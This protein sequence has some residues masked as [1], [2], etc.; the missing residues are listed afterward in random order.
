MIDL[1]GHSPLRGHHSALPH[2]PLLHSPLPTPT[3]SPATTPTRT[4]TPRPQPMRL[5][6]PILVLALTTIACR[7]KGASAVADS[8]GSASAVA[9][10][11]E[12]V[13]VKAPDASFSVMLPSHWVGVFRVDTLST[14]ERGSA[15][16]GALNV[17]Y[18]PRDSSVIPQTLVVVAV[19]DSAAW[20]RVKAAGGP[21]PGDSVFAKDGRVYILGLPQS[22]PFAP[23]SAD[24]LK[25]DSLAL[26]AAD[27]ARM[28]RVP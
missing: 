21:P 23:G 17:V 24:A 28:I 6:G 18:L 14:A 20:T 13:M 26:T 5:R 2:S 4:H 22:N 7:D 1:A 19:Y 27:K 15:R 8:A 12:P 25:F 9:S 16:P 3:R 11:P 10:T